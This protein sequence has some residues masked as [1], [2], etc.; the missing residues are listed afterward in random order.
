M[1]RQPPKTTEP[2][3]SRLCTSCNKIRKTTQ[4]E[5]FKDGNYRGVCRDCVLA[6]RAKKTSATPEAYLKT[7][8]VQLK[9]QRR[10]QGIEFPLAHEDLCQM[11]ETQDGRCALSGVLMTHH[12]DGALGDGKQKDLNASIDRVNPQGPYS[13]E[14]VQLAAA[15]VNIMKHTLGEEM[16]VWWIKNIYER[17]IK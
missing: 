6:Q 11:W 9:S 12:R 15:R 13:R 10:K 3:K 2:A 14:N 1:P 16:F 4:F 7:V 8:Y 5:L 17:Q